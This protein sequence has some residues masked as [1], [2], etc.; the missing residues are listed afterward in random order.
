MPNFQFSQINFQ[1]H[2]SVKF[3][4]A[5]LQNGKTVQILLLPIF[6]L[7]VAFG[8]WI[9]VAQV[10]AADGINKTINFQGKLV[11]SSGL[12]VADNTYSVVFTLY[13]A[14]S[15]GSNLWDETQS[16]TTVDG[17]FHVALGSVDT[18]LGNVNFNSDSLYL[19]IKVGADAEMTPRIRMSAVPYAFNSTKVNGLTVT[20]TSDNPFSSATTLK[21]GDGKTVVINNGLTFSGTDG[22]TFTFPNA[23]GTVVTLDASQEL[24]NK[25]IGSTGLTF[26]GAGTDITSAANEDLTFTPNGTGDLILTSDFNSGVSIGTASNTSAVLSVNGGIGSNASFI[27]NNTNSGDLFVASQAGITKFRVANNGD[28]DLSAGIFAGGTLGNSS[29]CLTGGA[30]VAWASCGT[31]TGTNY[32][33]VTNG[34]V[35]PFSNTLDL[36]VG[37]TSSTSAVFKVSPH[38]TSATASVSANSSYAGLVVDN[39]GFGDLFTAS[40]SGATKFVINNAGNVEA[41]SFDGLPATGGGA[42]D[43]IT[44]TQRTS[45]TTPGATGYGAGSFTPA[46]TFTPN[47]GSVLIAVVNAGQNCDGS[48]FAI[49]GSDL[50]I[51]GGSL[52]WVPITGIAR[53]VS[54]TSCDTAIRAFY[55]VVGGSPPSN[56]QVTVDAGAISIYN[57][58]VYVHEFANVDTTTPVLGEIAGS[59]SSASDNELFTLTLGA[60]PATGDVKIGAINMNSQDP[61]SVSNS[62]YDTPSGWTNH[63]VTVTSPQFGTSSQ[64]NS[65]TGSTSTTVNFDTADLRSPPNDTVYIGFIMNQEGTGSGDATSSLNIGTTN[66]TDITLGKD[67]GTLTLAG[68]LSCGILS[69]DSTGLVTCD[70]A[71]GSDLLHDASYD[72]NEALQNIPTGGAQTALGTVSVTPGS[73]IADVYVTGFA[74]VRSGNNTDQPFL[75]QVETTDNCTGSVVGEASVT[76]TL[77][78]GVSTTVHIGNVKVS[79]VHVNPGTSAQPYSLCA[80]VSS[81]AGDTDVLNWGIEAL[82]IDPIGPQGEAGSGGGTNYLRLSEGAFSPVNDTTDFLI[83]GSATSSAKFGFLNV[84]GTGTPTASVS[85][86]VTGG[87]YMTAT[88]MIQTTA[89]QTLTLG[90]LTTGNVLINPQGNNFVGIGTSNPLAPLDVRT[91]LGT[92][93]TASISALSSYATLVIDNRGTGDLF[94]ASSSGLNR[95]VIKQNGNVG[96]GTAAPVY[97]LDV[98]GAIRSTG[99]SAGMRLDAQDLSGNF[100]NIYSA[101]GELTFL[102]GGGIQTTLTSGGRWGIGTNNTSPQAQLD[103]LSSLGTLPAALFSGTTSRA[104]VVVENNGVGD[105]FTASKSGATKFVINNAGNVGIGTS[106]PNSALNIVNGTAGQAG[107]RLRQHASQSVSPFIVEDSAGGLMASINQFGGIYTASGLSVDGYAGLGTSGSSGTRLRISTVNTNDI[108]FYTS[109]VNGQTAD[110]AQFNPVFGT[111]GSAFDESA[112]L[113]I[114]TSAPDTGKLNITGAYTGKALAIFNETGNQDLFTAS[115]G[116]TTR[117]TITNAGNVGIGTANPQATLDVQSREGLDA[118]LALDADEGDDATDSWF[119]ESEAADNDLSFVNGTT[120]YLKLT[121]VGSVTFGAAGYANCTALETAGGVLTC[122]TDDSTPSSS[123]NFLQLNNGSF[124]FINNTADILIG[125]NSS[126]SAKFAFM[127]LDSNSGLDP[128]ASFGGTLRLGAKNNSTVTQQNTWTAISNTPGQIDA[129]GTSAIASIS[130]M[131]TY[132]GSVY[133]GTFKGL[134]TAGEAEIYRYDGTGSNWTKVTQVAA[135]TIASG[136]TS[137]IASVSAMTIFDGRLYAGT[138]KINSAEVYRYEG[139]TSWTKVSATT[140]G[141]IGGAGT[142]TAG[143]DGVSSMAVYNGRLYAGTSDGARA[144]LYRYDGGNVWTKVS[145]ATAGT[146]VATNTAAVQAVTSMVVRNGAL[147]IGTKKAGDADVL[148]YEGGSTDNGA[149]GGTFL[150]MNNTGTTGSYIINGATAVTAFDEVTAMTVYNGALVVALRRGS[151]QADILMQ[152]GGTTGTAT[153]SW[154]RLNNA[155]GQMTQSGTS[156]IDAVSAMSVYNGQLYIATQEP[157]SAEIYRYTGGDQRFVKVTQA[158]GTISATGGSKTGIDGVVQL[159]ASNGDLYAGTLEQG[160]AEVYKHTSSIDRSHQ[161]EFH[162][163]TQIAGGEQNSLDNHASIFY[164]ASASANLGSSNA[165]T[166]AFIFS[167]GIQTRNGSYDVAEDYPTRDDTLEP[168]DLVSIDTDE[169][170][171]VKKSQRAYESSVIGVYSENPALRL[172]QLDSRIDG[173]RAIPVALAGRVPVKVSTENGEIKAGDYL[174]ASSKPGIAMKASKSGGVIGQAMGGYNEDGVGKVLTYITSSSYAGNIAGTFAAF[175]LN[176]D[177][178][179]EDILTA[180]QSQEPQDAISEIVTDKLVAGLSIVSQ[181]IT[182][183]KLQINTIEAANASDIGIVLSEDGTLSVKNASDEAGIIF[184]GNGD[185]YFAGDVQ[186][187]GLHVSGTITADKLQV[188]QIEIS[189]EAW[190]NA[191]EEGGLSV[192]ETKLA[193]QDARL[194]NLETL[195]ASSSAVVTPTPAATISALIAQLPEIEDVPDTD[196]SIAGKST[197][198]SLRVTGSALIEGMLHVVDFMTVRNLIVDQ[199]ATFLGNVVFSGEVF[200]EE[201]PTFNNDTAGIAVIKKGSKSIEVLFE[202]EY[203]SAPMINANLTLD[204]VSPMPSE[205]LENLTKRQEALEARLFKANVRYVITKRSN[206]GFVILLDKKAEEDVAFSWIAVRVDN[207]VVRKGNGD[208]STPKETYIKENGRPISS[209]PS[210]L[211]PTSSVEKREEEALLSPEEEIVQDPSLPKVEVDE[212]GGE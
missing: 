193:E 19:G 48:V 112:N 12:N 119:I 167:H 44:R 198:D 109:G 65:Q 168:G 117:F 16:V 152:G 203:E 118:V 207:P 56:M 36:L 210:I 208:K 21:I 179:S 130:A 134:S 35:S 164:L 25:T 115:A 166:G 75:L 14:D 49:D 3:F 8:S 177:A 27:V 32:W 141:T 142:P 88:G 39:R 182:A 149:N 83:G 190:A 143:I 180:L 9:S 139:G 1:N 147:Y 99:T 31:G 100:Y 196:S 169:R 29:Q 159:H 205:E 33:Q 54:D 80:S 2:F 71:G 50:T 72:T 95:F 69:T 212:E 4:R 66:A 58:N 211:V 61:G 204:E 157:Q 89:N 202:K 70:E 123:T 86:G 84:S 78:S 17:I 23:T 132:N 108:G 40:K 74:E 173:A 121:S 97:K 90:G 24:T 138:S 51:S 160:Q 26:S 197:L 107:L 55:A 6:V 187:D 11:N 38:G 209:Y 47:A 82:V 101:A 136:G 110:L 146:F 129:S 165:N 127:N 85:A 125:G 201:S 63:E 174:T 188:N 206:K 106:T 156:G 192:L 62:G 93:P 135:G 57:Y 144:E 122:G 13:D 96:I 200:F 81:G 195:F 113:R 126:S 104:A 60:T 15:G 175:E 162:A 98:A 116:G 87:M 41:N 120:E 148:R 91:S 150:A 37:G 42:P 103:V 170:G 184:N 46:G 28:L 140:A 163:N 176:E 137:A 102:N 124:S 155:V 7:F 131:A 67:G 20:N 161:L 43:T 77:T 30:T 94:T 185:A 128:V 158:A 92:V 145:N 172:S 59:R 34:T 154:T 189:S 68:L 191:F 18:S 10:L 183:D 53:A 181:E 64:L 22:T 178:S 79:G 199:L 111:V 133:V 105:L 5:F 45:A 52:T 151:G 114:G 186:M 153:N 194:T 76:Y 171:F 73:S